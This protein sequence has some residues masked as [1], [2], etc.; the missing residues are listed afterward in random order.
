MKR[1]WLI[2]EEMIGWLTRFEDA[3]TG[4]GREI[5]LVNPAGEII[6]RRLVVST[7]YGVSLGE[8]YALFEGKRCY[9]W[10]DRAPEPVVFIAELPSEVVRFWTG[11]S[12]MMYHQD[13]ISPNRS[14][15]GT[16]RLL[17]RT[18]AKSTD[19]CTR[20]MCERRTVERYEYTP[21]FGSSTSTVEWRVCFSSEPPLSRAGIPLCSELWWDGELVRRH[22]LIHYRAASLR[23]RAFFQVP[24]GATRR[25]VEIDLLFATPLSG[26]A[27]P[28]LLDWRR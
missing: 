21:P 22:V 12:L 20:Y 3:P 28:L 27:P 26:F 17:E 2:E 7:R 23:E 8:Y 1:D 25:K 15:R 4:Y 5:R 11:R 24:R 13:Y 16:W 19:F 10:W 14:P 9:S 18:A 6:G